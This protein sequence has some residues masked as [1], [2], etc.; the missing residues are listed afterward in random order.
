MASRIGL[1]NLPLACVLVRVLESQFRRH[2]LVW[3]YAPVEVGV[4]V[5]VVYFLLLSVKVLLGL[6][7]MGHAGQR[8]RERVEKH[9]KHTR[10]EAAARSA[11]RKTV[12]DFMKMK[13]YMIHKSRVP[14]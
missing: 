12:E 14:M 5:A 13:R 2:R 3:N 9:E 1:V 11:G 4:L 8:Y 7:L 10:E 6:C